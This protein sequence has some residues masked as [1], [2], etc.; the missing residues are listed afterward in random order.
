MP[1]THAED[2]ALTRTAL[3]GDREAERALVERLGCIPAMLRLRERRLGSP[4]SAE[5]RA[6][7][8]QETALAVWSKLE[9]YQG[10]V[11]LEAWVFGF[12]V[13]EHYKGLARRRRSGSRAEADE[14]EL[15][16]E[17]APEPVDDWAKVHLCI[18]MLGS[19]SAE[20]VRLRHFEESSFRDIAL[21]L[22]L[23][24]NTVKTKYYRAVSRLRLQLHS[25]W[26]EALG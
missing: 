14:H 5:E 19:P 2:E 17:T 25:L 10:R 18:H 12:V 22:D 1:P 16:D 21:E 15:A 4:L 8:V 26:K 3:R 11:P 7:I 13:R 20:I 23:P 24:E 9:R 6:E